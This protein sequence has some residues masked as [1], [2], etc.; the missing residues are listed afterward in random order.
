M[1][2][3]SQRRWGFGQSGVAQATLEFEDAPERG[4]FGSEPE[5]DPR[6]V[7]IRWLKETIAEAGVV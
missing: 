1:V 6:Y 4:E 5:N 7:N 2:R 3:R